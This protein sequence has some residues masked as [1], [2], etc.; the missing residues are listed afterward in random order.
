MI[1]RFLRQIIGVFLWLCALPLIW[2]FRLDIDENRLGHEE[3][4]YKEIK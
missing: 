4:F 1:K 3:S 2:Y